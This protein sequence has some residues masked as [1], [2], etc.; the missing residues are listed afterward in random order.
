ML[1][2]RNALASSQG[3]ARA[4]ALL[5]LGVWALRTL[6][7]VLLSSLAGVPARVRV[8][9]PLAL[10]VVNVAVFMERTAEDTVRWLAESEPSFALSAVGVGVLYSLGWVLHGCWPA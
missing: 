6:P 7:A 10:A 5:L 4:V 8:A 2:L 1:G 3:S 9:L